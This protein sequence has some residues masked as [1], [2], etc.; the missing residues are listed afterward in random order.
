[1]AHGVDE[2]AASLAAFVFTESKSV[3][4]ASC[5]TRPNSHLVGQS[6]HQVADRFQQ[7]GR[8]RAGPHVELPPE[9][10]AE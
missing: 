5:V 10:D 7:F 9:S 2:L 8:G 6:L 3:L 4:L 1:M